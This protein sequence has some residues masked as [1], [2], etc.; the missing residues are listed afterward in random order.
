MG[1]GPVAAASVDLVDVQAPGAPGLSIV[2][3]SNTGGDFT[4]ANPSADADGSPLTGLTF[5]QA[6]VLVA[7]DEEIEGYKT[8]FEAGQAHP[9][10]QNFT[11]DLVAGG[12]PIVTPYTIDPSMVGKRAWVIG[13][14]ADHPK[15]T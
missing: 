1:F 13:R 9:G 5:G 2:Q 14:A 4:F 10:A 15:G 6:V 8:N 7:T 11:L 3:K 12:D